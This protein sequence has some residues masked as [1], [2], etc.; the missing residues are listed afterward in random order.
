MPSLDPSQ[1]LK[2]SINPAIINKNE[3][4]ASFVTG[5]ENVQLT[6]SELAESIDR[7]LAFSSQLSGRRRK[8]SFSCSGI[9][10]VDFDGQRSVTDA[11]ADPFVRENASLLYTTPRHSPDHERFRLIFALL[12]PI[13]HP[14]RMTAILRSLAL[15]VGGSRAS[16]DPAHLFFGSKGSKPVL[17]ILALAPETVDA[18]IRQGLGAGYKM[19]HASALTTVSGQELDP[20][21]ELFLEDRTKVKFCDLPVR[22]RVCCPFHFDQSGS[23]FVTRSQSGS[24][25]LHCLV[26]EQTFWPPRTSQ[27]YDF[28]LFDKHVAA[29]EHYFATNRDHGP[30]QVAISSEYHPGLEDCQIYR[31]GGGFLD[32]GS[33]LPAGISFIK[34]PKGTGKT[35]ALSQILRSPDAR[36]VLLIGHRI[37][38]ISQT[39]NRL[40]LECYL[41]EQPGEIHWSRLGICLDSLARLSVPTG[42]K[43]RK[44]FIDFL[45]IDESE[46]VL[47]HFLGQTIKEADRLSLFATFRQLVRGAKRVVALDADLGWLTFETLS[48]MA[49]EPDGSYVPKQSALFLNERLVDTEVEV[50]GT[51][52]QLIGEHQ[53]WARSG[54]RLFVPSNSKRLL[55]K[56][57]HGFAKDSPSVRCLLVTSDTTGETEVKEF[58]RNPKEEALK[59]DVIFASPTLGTGIDITFEGNQSLIDGFFG[60]FETSVSTHFVIDQQ[61]WRVRHPKCVK[62]WISPAEFH[63]D[64]SR[65]VIRSDL[66]RQ[67]LFTRV[68]SHYDDGGQP[69]YHTG[70]RLID[71]AALVRS[72][73]VA[74]KNRLK[75]NFIAMKQAHGHKIRHV[76]KDAQTHENGVA[77]DKKATEIEDK[78][79]CASILN[80]GRLTPD[81]FDELDAREKGKNKTE[82]KDK[83]SRG[84]RGDVSQTEKFALER[85]RMERF[86]RRPVDKEMVV[87]DSRGTFR[88]KV[89]LFEDVCKFATSCEQLGDVGMSDRFILDSRKRTE[90]VVRLLTEVGIIKEGTF[91]PTVEFSH[92][93]LLDFMTECILRRPQI[94]NLLEIEVGKNP[95]TAV[96][97]LSKLLSRMGLALEVSRVSRAKSLANG[98]KVRF[99]TLE[100]LA[101]KIVEETIERRRVYSPALF[102]AD[103]ASC[104]ASITQH[105]RELA[106]A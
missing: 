97:V 9:L 3:Q 65:D 82:R 24:N 104:E 80:A 37:A 17:L 25:G 23:A 62:V 87:Q 33:S 76:S 96:K 39:C 5:F 31:Q 32:L 70:D 35:E 99:Y 22:T 10:T 30:W 18:L 7:G 86:Y 54:R 90:L 106:P 8:T 55:S 14:V 60:F 49:S 56:L 12:E 64:T 2:L 36:R 52:Q 29:V 105:E 69:V 20:Q 43:S 94:E 102:L 73:Q 63:F 19:K 84:G 58:I 88:K 71:M 40:T 42:A 27:E 53:A 13:S 21:P 78:F 41:D 67:N 79:Y 26:C 72:Q 89:M 81:E 51:T 59:Y 38:L 83:A 68:L 92:W 77:F 57:Y 75:K 74:S 47:G 61:I 34:S 95:N 28:L 48:K 91:D 98:G 44:P 93:T 103:P 101:L 4:E 45:V 1:R 11:L 85:Y 6:L 66:Q 50:N 16:P 15:R 46:Q 100:A